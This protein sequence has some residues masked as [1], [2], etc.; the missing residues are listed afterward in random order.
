M[1]CLDLEKVGQVSP[2]WRLLCPWGREAMRTSAWKFGSSRLAVRS[3][4]VCA[5][6][7]FLVV[8]EASQLRLGPKFAAPMPLPQPTEQTHLQPFRNQ[9]LRHPGGRAQLR[10][11]GSG[12]TAPGNPE[13]EGK[14]GS[15]AGSPRAAAEQPAASS[16]SKLE[17]A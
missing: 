10:P 15:R 12:R 5:R 2:S 7:A 9:F 11:A 3:L 1:L 4:R 13:A 6:S 14:A 17:R 16:D 8:A